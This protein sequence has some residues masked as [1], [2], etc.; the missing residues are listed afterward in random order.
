MPKIPDILYII[1]KLLVSRLQISSQIRQRLMLNRFKCLSIKDLNDLKRT[2]GL[3]G[4]DLN[5]KQ[6]VVSLEDPSRSL[7]VR[8]ERRTLTQKAM[9]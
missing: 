5:A 9:H 1:G 4:R 7:K 3:R 6:R 8:Q 2:R